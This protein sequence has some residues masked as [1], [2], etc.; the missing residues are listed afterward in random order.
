VR[1]R[2]D[3]PDRHSS[4]G[5]CSHQ[6]GPTHARAAPAASSRSCR[7]HAR[8]LCRLLAL[9]PACPSA[10]SEPAI[11]EADLDGGPRSRTVVLARRLEDRVLA[12][13]QGLVH[14]WARGRRTEADSLRAVAPNA[15]FFTRRTLDRLLDRLSR[16][17]D[18]R[19]HS[20]GGGQHRDRVCGGQ[21]A[22]RSRDWLGKRALPGGD[23]RRRGH[24]VP[25]RYLA[26]DDGRGG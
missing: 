18:S 6:A 1:W 9:G 20:G 22:A 17:G 16:L 15:A 11:H 26:G 8:G 5:A 7:G 2:I 23:A 4:C 24:S 12:P 21:C 25:G 3:G 19:R 14:R 10:G 13:R